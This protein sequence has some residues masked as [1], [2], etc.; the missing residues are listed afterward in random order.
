MEVFGTIDLQIILYKQPN[1]HYQL[2]GC[3]PQ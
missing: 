3:P 1:F 2:M